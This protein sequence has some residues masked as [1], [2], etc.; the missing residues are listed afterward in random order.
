MSRRRFLRGMGGIALALPFLE[1]FMPKRTAGAA[2]TTKPMRY[3]FAFGGSSI[4]MDGG[5]KVAPATEGAMSSL[6]TRGTQPLADLG[7]ADVTSMVSGLKIPWGAT[8][9]SGGRYIGFH[10]SS[11]CPLA[12]VGWSANCARSSRPFS[13]HSDRPSAT[14]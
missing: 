6:I 11:T 7:V 12:P 4:G 14:L 8:I 13:T 5:Q 10:A 1:I 9:P 3:V 2:P